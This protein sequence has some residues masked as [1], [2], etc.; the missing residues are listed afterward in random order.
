MDNL[1]PDVAIVISDGFVYALVTING[2]NLGY[3]K[4]PDR[5]F[6]QPQEPWSV[7][8][9]R[10]LGATGDA[11][12]QHVQLDGHFLSRKM[13]VAAIVAAAETEQPKG[14]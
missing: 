4:R 7:Y 1:K 9:T 3:A 5:A 10:P 11:I 8:Q 14:A 13:A 2:K 12:K 6:G